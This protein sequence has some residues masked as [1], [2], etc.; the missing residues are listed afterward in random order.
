LNFKL[1]G[2]S[3]NQKVKRTIFRKVRKETILKLYNTLVLPTFL[4]GSDNWTVDS[5][6]ET[7]I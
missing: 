6:T 1:V 7:E 5:L 2:A 3:R 4:Y